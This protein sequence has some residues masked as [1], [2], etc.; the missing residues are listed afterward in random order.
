MN[1]KSFS[2][3]DVMIHDVPRG[4]DDHEQLILTDLTINL[5]PDLRNYF[6]RKI[7]D[8]LTERGVQVVADKDEDAAVRTS[9]AGVLGDPNEL[10]AASRAIATRLDEVQTGRNPAGLLAVITARWTRCPVSPS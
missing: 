3:S 9:L 4:N 6:R 2:V 8:S 1:L 7:V 5:D 10:I